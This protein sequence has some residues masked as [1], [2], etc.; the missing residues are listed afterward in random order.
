MQEHICVVKHVMVNF[1]KGQ[2][3]HFSEWCD[4]VLLI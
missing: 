1:S 2:V 4:I 3:L